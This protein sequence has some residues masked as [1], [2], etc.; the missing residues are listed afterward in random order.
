VGRNQEP[1]SCQARAVGC[2]RLQEA[3][4]ARRKWWGTIVS[5]RATRV[6]PRGCR[7]GGG[8]GDTAADC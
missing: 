7:V 6:V 1:H 8:D 4:A 3:R 5:R 2:S